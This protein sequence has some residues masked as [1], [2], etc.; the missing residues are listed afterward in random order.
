M[1]HHAVVTDPRAWLT[2]SPDGSWPV[3]ALFDN[4]PGVMFFVKDAQG[5]YVSVNDTLRRRIGAQH[6]RDVIG[7]TA[8][9]VF[10][11]EPGRRFNEQDERTLREGRELRDVL[12]MYVGTHGQAIWCLTTKTPVLDDTGRVVGLA[13]VSRDVPPF[14]DRHEDFSRVASVLEFMRAHHDEPLRVPDLAARAGV[15]VDSF[16]RLVRRVCHVTPKQFLI[17][18]RFDA[19]TRL[20][21]ESTAPIAEIAHACGY[22]DHSAFTR[23]FREVTGISPHVYRQRLQSREITRSRLP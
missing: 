15:S 18:V 7:R 21:R 16:E 3:E 23:K 11:G 2:P 19:A 1:W 8:A 4:L 14:A 12:E 17:R 10:T 13:G 20:L 6:K 22:S 9:E 5:R